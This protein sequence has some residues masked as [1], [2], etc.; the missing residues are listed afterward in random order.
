MEKVLSYSHFVEEN[1]KLEK[2]L[3][4]KISYRDVCSKA[5]KLKKKIDRF[6]F[7][8]ENKPNSPRVIS[9]KHMDDSFFEIKS[10][11]YSYIGNFIIVFTE[12]HNHFVYHLEDIKWVKEDN[13]LIYNYIDE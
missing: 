11:C 6:C 4:K 1:N 10:A 8:S 5:D 9:W 2:I 12:H 7:I 13:R 3:G